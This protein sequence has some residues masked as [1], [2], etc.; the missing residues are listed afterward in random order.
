MK[1]L[2]LDVNKIEFELIKPELE[3]YERDQPKKSEIDEALVLFIAV[4]DGDNEAFGSKAVADAIGFAGKLKRHNLVLY[5][6]AHLSSN[7]EEPQRAM[8]LFHYMIKEAEKSKMK[9]FHAPFGWNKSLKVDVKGHPLAEMSRNYG[10]EAKEAKKVKKR[11]YDISLAKKVDW[12]GLPDSDHRTIAE[13][14]DLFTFQEVSPG[15]VYWH[16]N[17]F[18]IYKELVRFI[19]EKLEEYGYM[20]VSTPIMADT[21]LWHISGHIDHY[22]ENMFILE[23][24]DH[25]MGLKPMNCP[26]SMLIFK[27]RKRSYRDLPQRY[28]EFG[29]LYRN[30]ISGALTGLFRVRELVQDDAHLFVRE[31]QMKQELNSIL[32]LLE[33]LYKPFNFTQKSKLS[34]MPDSRMGSDEIWEKATNVLKEVMKENGMKYELKEKEGSFYGPKIDFDIKDSMGREWQCATVQVDYNM[35]LRFGL[36]YVGEDGKEHSPV[37]LHK[38]LYGSLERFIGILIEHLQGKFPTWLAP[39]QVRVL[40]ISEK[41]NKYAEEVFNQLKV[42]H[43][44]AELDDSDKTLPYKIRDGQMQQV[45]YMIILG[46]KEMEGK[47][48]SVRSRSGKQKMGLSIDEFVSSLKSEIAERKNELML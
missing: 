3:T 34:T 41:A 32:K 29:K 16:N 4:E 40:T 26:F 30:E 37:V 48:I 25:E 8:N 43:I 2:Q 46:E 12:A 17:G 19:R 14:Q 47:T 1:I 22:R 39:I 23:S 10:A 18:I 44:R 21:A 9:V 36:S 24:G 6:F 35:P 5:P 15:M 20:E 38:A 45:P 27:S 13:K 7:L 28:A 42:Q 33:E 11:A 31:D